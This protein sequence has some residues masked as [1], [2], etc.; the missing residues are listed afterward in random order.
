MV[1]AIMLG[2]RGSIHLVGSSLI[3]SGLIACEPAYAPA[4]APAHPC[5]II[6]AAEYE[7]YIEAG[8]SR[9]TAHVSNRNIIS[10]K[11]GPGIRQCATFRGGAMKPCRRP[12]DF[13]IHYTVESG[14]SFYV[15]VPAGEEYRFNVRRV[16]NTC[17]ILDR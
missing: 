14:G 7:A 2:R 15:R 3:M 11:T 10:M 8:A 4:N 9:A 17:E 1:V 13:V 12:N 6:S 16:P 5:P